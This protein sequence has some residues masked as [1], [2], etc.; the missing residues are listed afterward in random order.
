MLHWYP[1]FIVAKFGAHTM[2]I[3]ED[4][5]NLSFQNF[6]NDFEDDIYSN[7]NI[8]RTRRDVIVILVV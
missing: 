6:Q 2:T 4:I 1:M 8:S 7:S 5:D 3:L